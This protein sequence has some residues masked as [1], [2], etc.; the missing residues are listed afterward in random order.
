MQQVDDLSNLILESRG[1]KNVI[2][3]QD[4]ALLTQG[5]EYPDQAAN[6]SANNI[7]IYS[8]NKTWS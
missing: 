5:L 6:L 4:K 7:F 1:W 2:L 8:Y 3:S